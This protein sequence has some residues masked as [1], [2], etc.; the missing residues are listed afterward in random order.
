MFHHI[1]HIPSLTIKVCIMSVC[2]VDI[3]PAYQQSSYIKWLQTEKETLFMA[4]VK[5][6]KKQQ[7]MMS[8]FCY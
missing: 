2:K 1:H 8:S 6:W 5:H 3:S 4:L 7:P